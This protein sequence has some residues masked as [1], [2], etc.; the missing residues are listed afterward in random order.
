MYGNEKERKKNAAVEACA[1]LILARQM[2]YESSGK[3]KGGEDCLIE[4][5]L[6]KRCLAEFLCPEEATYYYGAPNNKSNGGV[7]GKND[8]SSRRPAEGQNDT[9]GLCALWGESFAFCR[10]DVRVDEATKSA[11]SRGHAMI[12]ADKR[13]SAACR[14]RV[15]TLSKC[16]ATYSPFT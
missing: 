4:E 5:L 9:K 1:E 2:C 7:E 3:S 14:E 15:H 13:H 10:D 12:Q 6:E 11:H 8:A 16:L